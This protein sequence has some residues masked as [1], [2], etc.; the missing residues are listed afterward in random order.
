M[1]KEELLACDRYSEQAKLLSRNSI[2]TDS[3][4]T[5]HMNNVSEEMVLLE[6]KRYD[7]RLE[8]KRNVPEERK[9]LCKKEIAEITA[10]LPAMR[11]E[12]K[13]CEDIKARSEKVRDNLEE[14]DR[15]KT[16]EVQR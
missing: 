13:L 11:K 2:S 15:T 10:R 1:L 9:A 14:I 12:L 8:A 5:T 4:L 7:L 3:K 6:K 16:K